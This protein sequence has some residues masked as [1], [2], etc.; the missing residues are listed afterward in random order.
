MSEFVAH[1]S[2]GTPS[3][4]VELPDGSRHLLSALPEEMASILMKYN[5]RLHDVE[6]TILYTDNLSKLRYTNGRLRD[7]DIYA[8]SQLFRFS[9]TLE[10][11][12][13]DLPCDRRTLVKV[14][15]KP[16]R[17]GKARILG[18]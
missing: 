16:K 12:Y 4:F 2:D 6:N 14:F 1:I 3:V 9:P 11:P 15:G 5:N 8:T 7:A 17:W 18:V 13:I 10:G